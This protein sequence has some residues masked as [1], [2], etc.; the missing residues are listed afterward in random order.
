VAGVDDLWAG[1]SRPADAVRGLDPARPGL[2]LAHNPDCVDEPG[3]GG[4]AGWVLAGHTHGGQCKAPLF[5]PPALYLRNRRY[6]AGAVDLGGGR[7]LYVNRG[8]GYVQRVRFNARPEI[9]L[10]RL[11]PA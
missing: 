1:R 5:P 7:H 4:F 8:L 11:V 10:F 6:A 3:W 2:A 9:T